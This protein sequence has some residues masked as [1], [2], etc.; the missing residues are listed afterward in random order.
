L[1]H[2]QIIIIVLCTFI[3]CEDS[4]TQ[5]RLSELGAIF[6]EPTGIS[7]KIWISPT[8]AVDF[9]FGWSIGGDRKSVV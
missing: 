3:F 2:F 1:K 4:F 7:A 8:D 9:G 5:Q 6:G